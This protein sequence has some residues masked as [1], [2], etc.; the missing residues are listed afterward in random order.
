MA[1]GSG[2]YLYCS[3]SA[4]HRRFHSE[5]ALANHYGSFH[6]RPTCDTCGKKLKKSGQ[7][8]CTLLDT[9][10]S[11]EDY[12]ALDFVSHCDDLDYG[13]DTENAEHVDIVSPPTFASKEF[14]G[15]GAYSS[16]YDFDGF[17]RT[18]F[19]S[20][21]LGSLDNDDDDTSSCTP[22]I[23]EDLSGDCDSDSCE[24]WEDHGGL[25]EYADF[26]DDHRYD[27]GTKDESALPFHI[28]LSLALRQ[29]TGTSVDDGDDWNEEDS[30]YLGPTPKWFYSFYDDEHY[31]DREAESNDPNFLNKSL[32]ALWNPSVDG[33]KV[34]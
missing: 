14:Q 12:P 18:Q 23:T 15:T 19:S 2:D 27:D 10:A 4:C 3:H 31:F 17:Y 20:S 22:P 9:S 13:Y 34:V 24:I 7:H 16:S 28:H 5:R 30:D 1:F 32:T 33:V 25:D 8:T 26:Y 11:L 6:G 29:L 21:S